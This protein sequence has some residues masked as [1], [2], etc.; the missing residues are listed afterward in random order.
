MG[1]ADNAY[2]NVK[3]KRTLPYE[4]TLLDGGQFYAGNRYGSITRDHFCA[5]GIVADQDQQPHGESDN[6]ERMIVKQVLLK[7][8]TTALQLMRRVSVTI[9]RK[10][11]TST[12]AKM[13]QSLILHLVRNI[14]NN[15]YR[16]V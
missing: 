10:M 5:I 14:S 6:K 3:V 4:F 7:T 15:L 13:L 9:R 1:V 11:E 8:R 2:N 12:V 16:F